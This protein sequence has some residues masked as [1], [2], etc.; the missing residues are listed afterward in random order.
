MYCFHL[1]IFDRAALEWEKFVIIIWQIYFRF[2]K[3]IWCRAGR[4]EGAIAPP[5]PPNISRI[6]LIVSEIWPKKYKNSGLFMSFAPQYLHRPLNNL[7]SV[8]ALSSGN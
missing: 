5:P 8:P 6:L 2:F 4:A 1:G 3:Y 7:E